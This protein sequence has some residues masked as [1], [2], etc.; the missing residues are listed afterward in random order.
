MNENMF[1]FHFK[2]SECRFNLSASNILMNIRENIRE[3][4]KSIKANKL[5]TFLTGATIAIGITSLVGILTAIDGVQASIDDS[6]SNLGANTFDIQS[7]RANRGSNEGKKEK[8][9]PLVE[10]EELMQFKEEYDGLGTVSVNTVVS[11]NAEARYR[12][13]V[14][15]PN[16]MISGGDENF[17]LVD[18][19]DIG[20]GR[21]FSHAET[22]N[23]AYACM[24]GSQVVGALFEDNESPV[25]K[26]ITIL[27]SKFKVLGTLQ[28]QGGVSGNT[29]V[30]RRIVV[31]LKTARII[32]ADR[33]F[34]YEATVA[35]TDIRQ[36]DEATGV[37]TGL[38]RSIRR[39]PITQENSFEVRVNRSYAE[40]MGEIT[41]YLRAGGFTIGFVTLIGA[42]I[43]L[44]NIML[45]S[46][47]E[48]TREIGVRKA[49]GATPLKIR[50]QFLIEAM[51]VCQMGGIG[52]VVLGILVGNATSSFLGS[53]GFI[54]PWA[55]I[56]FW[57]NGRYD[58][59]SYVWSTSCIQSF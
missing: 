31:P 54:V 26:K 15:N 23:G 58:C 9:Y 14:T 25:G 22:E 18:G 10:Y 37:A 27:G 20:E 53:G 35:L 11:W 12:S 5:R 41:S 50:Q 17:L 29:G 51:L 8:I 33:I 7:K 39:D 45:V 52:G 24:I 30:D 55:W 36:M 16:M 4:V 6:F 40:R 48:R 46:V 1:I 21:S 19:Y 43:G 34:G 3:G 42:S 47:A 32:G 59:W 57:N 28:E 49:L 2:E 38:M 56:I 13:K 44:M